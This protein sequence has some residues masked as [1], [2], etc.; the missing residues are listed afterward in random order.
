MVYLLCQ[1]QVCPFRQQARSAEAYRWFSWQFDVTCE[2]IGF[3]VPANESEAVKFVRYYYPLKTMLKSVGTATALAILEVC[4]TART[5][6][7]HQLNRL[8]MHIAQP[9][10]N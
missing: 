10:H 5:T 6:L 9:Q 4:L 2:A 1:R 8:S 7:Q 3:N